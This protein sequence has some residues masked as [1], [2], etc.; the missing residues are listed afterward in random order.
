MIRNAQYLKGVM[1]YIQLK[2]HYVFLQALA[3]PRLTEK[4]VS[5]GEALSADQRDYRSTFKAWVRIIR[6]LDSF[7]DVVPLEHSTVK[8]E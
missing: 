2:S 7:R 8:L 5:K 3:F 1:V 6:H 4:L